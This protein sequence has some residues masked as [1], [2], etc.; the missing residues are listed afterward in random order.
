MT[1]EESL[2]EG[3]LD[4]ALAQIQQAVRSAP[5]D[6]KPRV[7]LFQ[8]MAVRGEWDRALNQLDVLS[9][10]DVATLPMAQAY[11]EAIAC[12]QL[13]Q[14]IFAG[15]R[16]PLIFGE[17]EPWIALVVQALGHTARGEHTQ[18]EQLRAAA[19]DQAPATSGRLNDQPFEWIADAD[20]RLGPLLEVMVNGR[21]YWVPFHRIH[22]IDIES[23]EDLRDFIW[24][25]AHFEWAT[26]GELMGLIPTRYPGSEASADSALSLSRKTEWQELG[27][28]TFAGLGQR[29]LATSDGELALMDVRR[30]DLDVSS[31]KDA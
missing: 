8:L 12:E 14:S 30:L 5:T 24:L 15:Q 19:F 13:R 21:Y 16:T 10:M 31:D 4:A 6:I 26:G 11:R 20:S 25:P 27:P 2:R 9:K 17:P 22:R 3:D 1:A 7:F 28:Q 18:A 29:M 23:P